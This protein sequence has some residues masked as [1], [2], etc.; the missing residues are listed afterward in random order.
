M[1]V[2][3]F[4][5]EKGKTGTSS[6]RMLQALN[7]CLPQSVVALLISGE[8][9][10]MANHDVAFAA[11]ALRRALCE[12]VDEWIDTGKSDKEEQPWKRRLSSPL[13]YG[14]IER[15]HPALLFDTEGPYLALMPRWETGKTLNVAITDAAIAMFLQLLDS[16]GRVRLFRCNGCGSYFL[17]QRMPKKD[18]P[19]YHGSWCGNCKGKGG[20]QR[21]KDT[22]YR[23]TEEMIGWGADAWVRWRQDRR[24]GARKEWVAR[25]INKRLPVDRD[26][27]AKNWVARHMKEI[28]LEVERR[29]HAEG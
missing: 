16:P 18:T 23:R 17:R 1:R 20:A 22:R 9:D 26:Q 13:P 15:N 12:M 11:Y 25:Y 4:V 28:E 27:I 6:R 2:Y 14:Y 3:G 7:G 29:K 19:I 8:P 24:H 10:G 5:G 21:I